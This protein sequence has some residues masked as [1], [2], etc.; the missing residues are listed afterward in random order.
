MTEKLNLDSGLDN[1]LASLADILPR[2]KEKIFVLEDTGVTLKQIIDWR[3]QG[4]L[5][6]D[7]MQYEK[8]KRIKKF[9]FNFYEF[10][11][12]DMI[13]DFK[14]MGLSY[15]VIRRL[16]EYLWTDYTELFLL[17]VFDLITNDNLT[18]EVYKNMKDKDEK[19]LE[20][21]KNA[22][23]PEERKRVEELIKEY[24]YYRMDAYIFIMLISNSEFK[25][26]YRYDGEILDLTNIKIPVEFMQGESQQEKYNTFFAPRLHFTFNLG[27]YVSRFMSA[28]KSEKFLYPLGFLDEN[29]QELLDVVRKGQLKELTIRFN[30]KDGKPENYEIKTGEVLTDSEARYVKE[31]LTFNDYENVTF[32]SNGNKTVYF[33]RSIKKR[34][35]K[36]TDNFGAMVK[37]GDVLEEPDIYGI[38]DGSENQNE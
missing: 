33:E 7:L 19:I 23:I 32:K 6:P 37:K 4:I 27:Y 8:G 20:M 12:M 36:A 3:K 35:N 17:G 2:M 5:S 30:S 24:K 14:E 16:K 15:S 26:A 29:E 1:T 28:E 38:L 13:R 9:E 11:W 10:I 25:I 34:L 21:K 31:M 22:S 18:N